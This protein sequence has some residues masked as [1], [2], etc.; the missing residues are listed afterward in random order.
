MLFKEGY[1]KYQL[2]LYLAKCGW[3]FK[4]WSIIFLFT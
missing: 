3:D 4:I 2:V 1:G